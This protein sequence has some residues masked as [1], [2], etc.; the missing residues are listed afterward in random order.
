MDGDTFINAVVQMLYLTD[1]IPL[2]PRV[3]YSVRAGDYSFIERVL[4]LVVFDRTLSLGM[5]FSVLCTED[6]DFQPQDANLQGLPKELAE[7]EKDSAAQFLETCSL[8][9]VNPLPSKVDE[10]VTSD[11]PTLVLSG[12]FDPITPPAYAQE[13]AKT[14]SKSYYFEFPVGGHGELTSGVCQDQIFLD[15][16]DDPN[17]KPDGSC[18][19]A[20]KMKFSTPGSIIPLPKLISLLN[21]QGTSGLELGMYGLALLFLLSALLVYPIAWL[22]SLFRRPAEPVMP[23]AV[24]PAWEGNNSRAVSIPGQRPWLYRLG[25]WLAGLAAILLLVFIVAVAVTAVQLALKN[26]STVLLGL[27]G[28]T[29]PLFLLPLI[30]LILS[31]LMIAAAA[32]AWLRK[33]GSLWSRLYFSLLTVSAWT[34]VAVLFV[35]GMLTA[36]FAG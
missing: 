20:Q 3:I 19:A 14:L 24:D 32:S 23:G 29:R 30:V 12:A 16:I 26:D 36:F 9:K 31:V 1:W 18:A 35:W 34:C 2:I 7:M 17:Q 15:F 4:S 13:A 10:A 22:V 25:P 27:P 5:Y 33:A 21:L 28:S 8:W 6:A 11:V